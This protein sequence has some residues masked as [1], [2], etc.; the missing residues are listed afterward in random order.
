MG[1]TVT[2]AAPP[3]NLPIIYA[4]AVHRAEQYRRQ[5]VGYLAELSELDQLLVSIVQNSN[6][7]VYTLS[8]KAE[9]ALQIAAQLD[10]A[11]S[12]SYLPSALVSLR[13]SL[14]T[15]TTGYLDAAVFVNAWVGQPT[16]QNYLDALEALRLARM[17]CQNTQVNPWLQQQ[18]L[19]AEEPIPEAATPAATTTGEGWSE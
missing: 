12:L 19:A 7:D 4:P 16:E 15:T 5:A 10:Q 6:E 18:T 14:Q 2:P 9:D 13:D 1:R 11:V 17:A 8:K 3:Q